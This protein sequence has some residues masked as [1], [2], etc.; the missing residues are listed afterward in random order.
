M[1]AVCF[2]GKSYPV[3][4]TSFVRVDE[5]HWVRC[6]PQDATGC[7]IQPPLEPAWLQARSWQHA[8]GHPPGMRSVASPRLTTTGAGRSGRRLSRVLG[9]EGDGAVP[10][11]PGSTARQR[12]AGPVREG[13]RIGLAVSRRSARGPPQRG[14]AP[15]GAAPR[16]TPDLRMRMHVFMWLGLRAVGATRRG[17]G[18][19]APRARPPQWPAQDCGYMVPPQPGFVQLGVSVEPLV[20]TRARAPAQHAR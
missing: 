6:R 17:A 13:R 19:P 16:L 3:P 2:I 7:L 18:P 5:T 1:F 15:A 11:D 14:H 8:Y 9:S 12:G 20:G 10:Y 4:D